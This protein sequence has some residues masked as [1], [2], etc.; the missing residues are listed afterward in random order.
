MNQHEITLQE[1]E[2]L[3]H[4]YQN[5]PEYQGKTVS[6]R[7]DN[8]A[9]QAVINQDDCIGIRTYFAK[10][11]DNKL[12]IVVVGVDANGNDMTDGVLLNRALGCPNACPSASSLMV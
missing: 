1:A 11:S 6:C 3:T 12:T 2:E 4:A 7:I 9:Y 8:E 10:N 5:D